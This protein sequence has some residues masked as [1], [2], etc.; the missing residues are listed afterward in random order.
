MEKKKIFWGEGA[1]RMWAYQISAAFSSYLFKANSYITL[2]A[3]IIDQTDPNIQ[4]N[5]RWLSYIV[6]NVCFDNEEENAWNKNMI[7]FSA[8]IL[9]H[10][11][12]DQSTD[13]VTNQ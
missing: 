4:P 8:S 6:G 3:T 2:S 12:H 10:Q 13:N 11:H 1:R 7:S 9:V 5:C